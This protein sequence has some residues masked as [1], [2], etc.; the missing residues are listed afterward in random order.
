MRVVCER[1]EMRIEPETG[2]R[3]I[4]D[5][6]KAYAYDGREYARE[7]VDWWYEA[8]PGFFVCYKPIENGWRVFV[9][10]AETYGEVSA[11]DA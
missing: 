3:I 6:P 1:Q 7:M 5:L 4:V 11:A 8:Y 9:E 2:T 10:I